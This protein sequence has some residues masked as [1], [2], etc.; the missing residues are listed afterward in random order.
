[1]CAT[2]RNA[3]PLD[4]FS[5]PEAP[6]GQTCVACLPSNVALQVTLKNSFGHAKQK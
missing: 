5:L 3:R 6:L 1:M 2:K 4:R